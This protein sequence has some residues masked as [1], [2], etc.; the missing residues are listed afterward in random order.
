MPMAR[1]DRMKMSPT[2]PPKIAHLASW[3]LPCLAGAE[4]AVHNLLREQRKRGWNPLLVTWWGNWMAMRNRLPYR[5]WP[6]LPKT[7]TL[8]DRAR[9][10]YPQSSPAKVALQ[11]RLIQW[12]FRPD[13]WH[14]HVAYPMGILCIP[15]L[16]GMGCKVVLTTQGGDILS[17]PEI[18]HGARLWPHVGEGIADC[19][20]R[21]DRLVAISEHIRREYLEL[22]VA[23]SAIRLIPNGADLERF[24]QS[25]VDRGAVRAR[26]GI[27]ADGVALITVGRHSP[28]KNYQALYGIARRLLDRGLDFVWLLVGTGT[29]EVLRQCEQPEVRARLRAICVTVPGTGGHAYDELP[30]RGVVE[31]LK[32]AD[33]YVSLSLLEGLSLAMVEASAAGLPLVSFK[34]PGCVDVVEQG[35]NGFLI[36]LGDSD[37]MAGQLEALIRDAALRRRMGE[38]QRGRLQRYD[39]RDIC[40]RHEWLYAELLGRTSPKPS[41]GP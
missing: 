25:S 4:V 29:D 27:S 16:K 20:R 19:V 32:A 10:R 7:F 33:V 6:L 28:Q 5:V 37:G 38:A 18:R 36:D 34:A 23:D 26:H 22:G 3:F 21:A 11:L 1:C 14:V 17:L 41:S 8:R 35:V 2:P 39:W 15:F 9:Y 12:I 31:L 30:P 24:A 40:D 13:V